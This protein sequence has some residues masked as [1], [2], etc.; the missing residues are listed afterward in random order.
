MTILIGTSDIFGPRGDESLLADVKDVD[1]LSLVGA[2]ALFHVNFSGPY[3]LLM[4]CNSVSYGQFPE[5]VSLMKAC[6]GRWSFEEEPFD[7]ALTTLRVFKCQNYIIM[8]L[9]VVYFI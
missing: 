9:L 2:I 3:W 7:V 6:L 8:F 4:N 5:Y 1:I